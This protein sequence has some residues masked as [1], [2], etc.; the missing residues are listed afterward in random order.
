MTESESLTSNPVGE[1][2]GK[3]LHS[4]IADGNTNSGEGNIQKHIKNPNQI[5][6]IQ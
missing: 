1:A 5:A 3:Q 2:V 6:L 4:Y